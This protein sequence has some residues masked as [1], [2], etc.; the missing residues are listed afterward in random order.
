[1]DDNKTKIGGTSFE[2]LKDMFSKG[3][4]ADELKN[5]QKLISSPLYRGLTEACSKMSDALLK[6]YF[7]LYYRLN[8]GARALPYKGIKMAA[9]PISKLTKISKQPLTAQEVSAKV[10]EEMKRAQESYLSRSYFISNSLRRVVNP[11]SQTAPIIQE[12]LPMINTNPHVAAAAEPVAIA[13][14]LS[15]KLLNNNT[16]A[17]TTLR[18]E[19]RGKNAQSIQHK[20]TVPVAKRP[21]DT[22]RIASDLT[23]QK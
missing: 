21:V 23:L 20:K 9:D 12:V 10:E 11:L 7:L 2:H 16:A 18:A 4:G 13:L 3:L 1:M 8:L 6:Q 19:M 17:L 22:K 15:N 14:Q 5:L